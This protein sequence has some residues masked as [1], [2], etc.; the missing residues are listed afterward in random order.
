MREGAI[1]RCK[2]LSDVKGK[3]STGT[4][5]KEKQYTAGKEIDLMAV[6][7]ALMPEQNYMLAFVTKDGYLINQQ[8]VMTLY[9]I[10]QKQPQENYADVV[11]SKMANEPNKIDISSLSGADTYMTNGMIAGAAI[12]LIYAIKSK[13]NK[14]LM[15]ALGSAGGALV[16]RKFK[17]KF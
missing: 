3:K 15:M 10:P 7:G 4:R 2:L 13:N 12:G 9:E 11:G 16:G 6:N 14:W 5:L 1:Y 17:K 8:A